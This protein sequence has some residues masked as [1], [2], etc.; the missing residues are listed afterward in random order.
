MSRMS[1]EQAL[2]DR[3]GAENDG[4]AALIALLDDETRSLCAGDAFALEAKADAKL[5]QVRAL[6]RMGQQRRQLMAQVS[7]GRAPLAQVSAGPAPLAPALVESLRVLHERAS[8]AK[9]I[10]ILNGRLI[11]RH[12]H[13][14]S[15]SLAALREAAG[16]PALYGADGQAAHHASNLSR[17]RV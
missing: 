9:R 17:A 6:E 7:P 1:D 5:A 11:D 13:Y 10:N 3:V 15:R 12:Q 14:A 8:E 2:A 4:Y 16:Q